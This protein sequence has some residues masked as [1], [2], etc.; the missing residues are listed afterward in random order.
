MAW[1][2][3]EPAQ[4]SASSPAWDPV[5]WDSFHG[6]DGF[7]VKCPSA[8]GCGHRGR[9]MR[10]L[11]GKMQLPLPVTLSVCTRLR[12]GAPCAVPA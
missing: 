9:K 10:E 5:E 3:R 6:L 8:V 1:L 11:W 2:H 7:P 12:A 4:L